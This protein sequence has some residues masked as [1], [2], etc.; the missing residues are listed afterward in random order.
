MREGIGHRR[1]GLTV[2]QH[3]GDFEL[4]VTGDQPQQLAGHIAGA[5]EHDGRCRSRSFAD[6]LGFA[7]IAQSQRGD[8]V[9]AQVR[10][11]AD[12]VE[13][14]DVHLLADDL[15]RPPDCRSRDR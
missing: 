12:G 4:R 1:A 11:I 8:D 10:G 2:G 3:R 14:F 6:D 7:H 9:I 13:G 15:A 5:A